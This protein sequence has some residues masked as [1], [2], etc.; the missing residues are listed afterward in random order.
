MSDSL[1]A[2]SPTPSPPPAHPTHAGKTLPSTRPPY[3]SWRKKY[4]KLRAR[5]ETTLESN[6]RLFKEELSLSGTAKRL[7]EELDGLA[8]LCLDLNQT[9]SVPAELRFNVEYNGPRGMGSLNNGRP[10]VVPPDISPEEANVLLQTYKTAVQTGSIPPLDLH[11]IREQID[12]RLAAQRVRPLALLE[13]RVPHA[14]HPVNDLLDE[15]AKPEEQLPANYLSADQESEYLLRLDFQTDSL[16]QHSLAADMQEERHLAEL[17]PREL[18]RQVELLN[19][20]S[21]HNWL[22]H[23]T[24]VGAE[25]TA[26]DTE[27]LASLHLHAEGGAKPSRKRA[28]AAGGGGNGK[29]NTL[30]RQA[31]E[32]ARE[33]F[34]PGAA[35]GVWEEDELSM[36]DE[37]LSGAGKKR[38]SR[39]AM[40]GAYRVKGGKSG[41]GKAKR[42]RTSD[43]TTTSAGSAKK[44]RTESLGGAEG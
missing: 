20:Q 44:A 35:S 37:Q 36:V 27:S 23:N 24:K 34:S 21:Q 7:R 5:F 28:H 14:E 9:A 8:E 26:D 29:G 43:E 4:R 16:P 2:P 11:V 30:A 19:P 6:R 33:G 18:E 41:G 38:G 31:V 25:G 15:L 3:K 13:K 12:Q 10:N 1:A 39:D 42:K 32:R 40:D 17:T 22:K